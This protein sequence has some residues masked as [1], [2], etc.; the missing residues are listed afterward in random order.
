M[1]HGNDS[2]VAAGPGAGTASR[3][4]GGP[5]AAASWR[6]GLVALADFLFWG[7]RAGL[8]LALFGLAL[9]AGSLALAR[10]AAGRRRGLAAAVLLLAIAPV[11][12]QLQL[13]SI[14]F[15]LLGLLAAAVMPGL[16]PGRPAAAYLRAAGRLCAQLPMV[17]VADLYRLLRRAAPRQS[18]WLRRAIARLALPLGLG[19]VFGGLVLIANPVVDGWLVDLVAALPRTEIQ[20]MRAVFW[21]AIACAAWP[22]LTV[23]SRRDGLER[24]GRPARPAP[25]LNADGPLFN[26]GSVAAT[27]VLVN[28]IL[29]LQNATDLTYLWGGVSLPAGLS[30]AEYAHRGAYPLVVTALLAGAFALAARRFTVHRPGLRALLFLWLGQNLLLMLS[31]LLRLDL[32]VDA[33]GLTRL[34]LAAA[35]WMG[36]VFVGLCLTAW[37]IARQRPNGWLLQANAVLLAA[38]LYACCFVNGS[39][40]IASVSLDRAAAGAVLDMRYLCRLGPDAAPALTGAVWAEKHAR[41]RDALGE[42][43]AR[44]EAAWREWGFRSWRIARYLHAAETGAGPDD[45]DD[46]DRR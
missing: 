37:Q 46:P 22:I 5:T 23:W 13:L 30:Y 20:P 39:N 42:A 41:C 38:V 17:P 15:L 21:A 32:Y 45:H 4:W 14:L 44:R 31:S 9:G 19:A 7:H 18:G 43:A 24:P 33:Y 34:R 36:L 40:L 11:V 35:I 2:A 25:T 8:S 29:G 10:P 28:L 3:A 26:A 12:E 16:G 1:T 6:V 27:L